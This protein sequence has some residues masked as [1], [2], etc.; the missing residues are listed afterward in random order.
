MQILPV[1]DVMHGQ[2]VRGVGG[3]REQYRPIVSKLTSATDPVLVAHAFR[4]QFGL[5][6]LYLADLDAIRGAVPAYAVFGELLRQGFRL[7]VDAGVG[8]SVADTL[9]SVGVQTIVVGLESVRGPVELNELIER[10]SARRI[11]FSLDA[12][13]GQPLGAAD[14]WRSPEL[15]AIAEQAVGLGLAR[16]LVLDLAAVGENRG[17]ATGDLCARLC[18]RHPHLEISTGG[19]IRG[20]EDVRRLGQQG[21]DKVLVA[22]ALHDGRLTP[23]ELR[24]LS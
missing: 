23:A 3:R 1:L 9:A 22:S 19:G 7:W 16:L 18:H 21:V 14:A 11:V 4:E 20:M 24:T 10:F 5:A 12:K 2:V 13:D 17:A 15:W 8:V 6:E